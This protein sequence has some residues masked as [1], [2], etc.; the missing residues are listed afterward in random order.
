MRL[1]GHIEL[2]KRLFRT[3]SPVNK[4]NNPLLRVLRKTKISKLKVGK[5]KSDYLQIKM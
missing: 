1:T 5:T 3:L 2:S 4:E